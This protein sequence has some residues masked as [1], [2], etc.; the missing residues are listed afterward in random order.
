MSCSAALPSDTIVICVSL[1]S[2]AYRVNTCEIA[3]LSAL[4]V[5]P[6][7]RWR[8]LRSVEASSCCIRTHRASIFSANG[9]IASQALVGI[10]LLPLRINS[11][12]PRSLSRERICLE[13][14][15]AVRLSSTAA[16]AKLR[17]L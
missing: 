5:T 9:T 10:S 15:E 3:L 13:T 7:T 12:R 1:C 17:S 2:D 16:A 8:T 11:G 14:A 4:G 6:T